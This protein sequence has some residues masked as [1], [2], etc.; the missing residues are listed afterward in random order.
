MNVF[1]RSGRCQ[2][3]LGRAACHPM[4]SRPVDPAVFFPDPRVDG[5][6]GPAKAVC[7]G[8]PVATECLLRALSEGIP[9]GVFGGLN[10]AE[11]Q[12]I[13]VTPGLLVALRVLLL[14]DR[15][16]QRI[17]LRVFAE[18]GFGRPRGIPA[19]LRVVEPGRQRGGYQRESLVGWSARVVDEYI[20][21]GR[22]PDVLVDRLGDLVARYALVSAS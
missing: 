5:A 17:T 12:L 6:D 14:A 13:T 19:E 11:R 1:D 15:L 20:C 7:A 16:P 8:C 21:S 10:E 18:F 22:C 2:A 4:A 3:W 9:H